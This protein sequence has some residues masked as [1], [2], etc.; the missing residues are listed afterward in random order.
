MMFETQEEMRLPPSGALLLFVL[1]PQGGEFKGEGVCS[2][3]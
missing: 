3:R 2:R 1:R